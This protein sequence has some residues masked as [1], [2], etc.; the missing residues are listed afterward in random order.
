VTELEKAATVT[1]DCGG[2]CTRCTGFQPGN[3]LARRHGR[4][5][6][7]ARLSED[8][9][10]AAYEQEIAETQPIGHPAD[11]GAIWRLALCYRRVEFAAAA[12]AEADA[13]TE[14]RPMAHFVGGPVAEAVDRMKADLDRWLARASKL[15][16]ELGRTPSSRAKLGLHLAMT[17]RALGADLLDRYGGDQS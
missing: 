4:W 14:G 5:V 11:A 12:L 13:A 7:D 1:H 15:E 6:S 3:E 16:A 17:G 9:Q 2:T 8:P 10:V